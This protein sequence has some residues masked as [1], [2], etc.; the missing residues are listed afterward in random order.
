MTSHSGKKSFFP[1]QLVL[2]ESSNNNNTLNNFGV[3]LFLTEATI[4][5]C[6]ISIIA[7]LKLKKDSFLKGKPW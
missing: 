1:L 6:K 2:L 5:F 4:N 3:S 7:Y